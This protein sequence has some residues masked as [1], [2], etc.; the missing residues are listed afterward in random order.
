[1]LRKGFAI[2]SK[3]TEN[4]NYGKLYMPL[5]CRYSVERVAPAG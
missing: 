3:M 2:A 4:A 1:M 5:R